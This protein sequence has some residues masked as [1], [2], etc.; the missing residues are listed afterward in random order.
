MTEPLIRIEKVYKHY[1]LGRQS[2][3]ALVDVTLDI[4]E[5]VFLA[6]AGP[7]GSGKS[8]LLNIIG[9]IDTATHGRVA[10]DGKEVS[11]QSPDDLADLRARTIGFVF[12][13]FNLLPVLT[14]AENIEYPLLQFAEL[15]RKERRKRVAAM[16]ELVGLAKH[17]AHR[18]NELSGGQRQR[19]AVARALVTQPRIILADEPTANLDSKTGD[20]ILDLMKEINRTYR[21]TFV[22]STHDRKVIAKADR[23]VRMEDGHIRRLG[24]RTTANWVLVRARQERIS[25]ARRDRGG[26]PK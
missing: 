9:C 16:L 18:P 13:T 23:L 21:T 24:V 5:G 20:G 14:A 12:Q 25:T 1:R 4:E 11:G 17:A 2:V 15:A 22:F 26:D 8:T 6:I 3:P 19:V 10:I 7:S